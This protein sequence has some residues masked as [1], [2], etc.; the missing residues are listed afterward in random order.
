MRRTPSGGA[1]TEADVTTDF[2]GG[3]VGRS[4]E[5]RRAS[6]TTRRFIRCIVSHWRNVPKIML[7]NLVLVLVAAQ[8]PHEGEIAALLHTLK[9]SESPLERKQ[10]V[11]ALEP[12]ISPPL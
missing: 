1:T 9:T 5:A 8:D 4:Q 7:L 2:G 11:K 6:A 3:G 10:A 12:W